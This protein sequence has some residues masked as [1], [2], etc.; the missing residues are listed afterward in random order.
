AASATVP[1][2]G[3]AGW[4]GAGPGPSHAGCVGCTSPAGHGSYTVSLHDALPTCNVSTTASAGI[5]LDQTA[6]SNGSIATTGSTGQVALS[7]T[8]IADAGSAINAGSHMPGCTRA[9]TPPAACTG[10]TVL[11]NASATSGTHTGR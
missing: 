9:G 5:G 3:A 1:A 6:P 4:T 10:R 7:W 2:A 11:A 8:G